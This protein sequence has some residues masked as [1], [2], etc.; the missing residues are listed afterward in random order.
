M[1]WPCRLT[2]CSNAFLSVDPLSCT[3]SKVPPK[4][5]TEIRSSMVMVPK[6]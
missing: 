6:E 4:G 2:A 3:R 5:R 1:P